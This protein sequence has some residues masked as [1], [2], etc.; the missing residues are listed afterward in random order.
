MNR[1]R[2]IVDNVQFTNDLRKDS[3]S[4]LLKYDRKIIAKHSMEVCDECIRLAKLFGEDEKKAEVAGILHDIG[5]IYPFSDRLE[6]SRNLGL[7]I[8]KEEEE[9]P[10]ILHQKISKV[11][12]REIWNIEDEEILS[13]I[14]CHTTL[15]KNPSKLDLIL[16]VADKIKWDQIG[17]PPYLHRVQEGLELSLEKAAYEY[18][19]YM[20]ENKD[21][22]KVIHPWLR[23]AHE[24]LSN[25][26]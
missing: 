18:I 4:I 19:S 6:V 12:A 20:M 5:G 16:F 13:A 25:E 15:K 9:L 1:F 8:L 3:N 14:S 11:M 17:E 10:L 23:E 24:Y 22:L 7:E 21:K 26:V 2:N